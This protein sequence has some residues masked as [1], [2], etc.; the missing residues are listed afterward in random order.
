MTA[1]LT[2]THIA[3]VGGSHSDGEEL[4]AAPSSSKCMTERRETPNGQQERYGGFPGRVF[5]SQDT[6]S[7]WRSP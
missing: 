7:Q 4:I 1:R 3:E 5:A 2:A 6:E